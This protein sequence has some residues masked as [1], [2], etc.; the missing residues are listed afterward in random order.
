MA[1]NITMHRRFITWKDDGEK[2]CEWPLVVIFFQTLN[3]L[4]YFV[5]YFIPITILFYISIYSQFFLTT[6]QIGF[7]LDN[8]TPNPPQ[9]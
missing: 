7:G 4:G 5:H 2:M 1:Y 6:C 9:M 8:P 3:L